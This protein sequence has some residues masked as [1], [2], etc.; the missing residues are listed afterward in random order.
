VTNTSE[1]PVKYH[2]DLHEGSPPSTAASGKHPASKGDPAKLPEEEGGHEANEL[3]DVKPIEGFLQ[4]GEREAVLVTYFAH[5]GPPVTMRAMLHVRGGP[6]VSLELK[7][8]P[9][10]MAFTF[11]PRMLDYGA[12]EYCMYASRQLSLFNTSK[13]APWLLSCMNDNWQASIIFVDLA[14]LLQKSRA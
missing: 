13:C 5:A 6:P 2:W 11:E 8:A 9:N 14:T 1:V 4:P 3:F 7:A 12:F 10:S